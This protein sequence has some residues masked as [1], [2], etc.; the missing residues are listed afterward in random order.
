MKTGL[1][2]GILLSA[3]VMLA[4]CSGGSSDEEQGQAAGE[5]KTAAAPVAEST[6]FR[7]APATEKEALIRCK[8]AAATLGSNLKTALKQAMREGCPVQA[9]GVC[10]TEAPAIAAA[11]DE[12]EGV[13]VGRTS[14]KWRNPDNAPDDWERGILEKFAADKAAGASNLDLETWTVV[15]GPDGGREFRYMKAILTLPL[16][17]KCHG[18]DLAPE[19]A[20]KLNELYPEDHA[21][22]Y[23]LGDLRGAFTVT[24]AM[25]QPGTEGD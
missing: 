7:K 11:I 16:C 4:G 20:T 24:V 12:R 23:G 2:M 22:G 14:L 5:G 9:L 13:T 10:N 15:V 21:T 6:T 8:A 1:M 18:T 19:V 3:A 17:L 25:A